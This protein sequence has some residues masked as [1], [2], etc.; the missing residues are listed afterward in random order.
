MHVGVMLAC[1]DMLDVLCR[2]VK[3]RHQNT[4]TCCYNRKCVTT[5]LE[6]GL[7]RTKR[8]VNQLKTQ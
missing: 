5:R 4:L 1:C 2:V 8:V 7:L 6:H 3:T